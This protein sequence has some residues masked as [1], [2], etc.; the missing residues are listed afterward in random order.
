MINRNKLN[1]PGGLY[2]AAIPYYELVFEIA[3]VYQYDLLGHLDRRIVSFLLFMGMFSFM[4]IKVDD[5]MLRAFMMAV[6]IISL[7]FSIAAILKYIIYGGINLGFGAK[8]IVGGQR[9]GFIYI[10]AFWVLLLSAL[11]SGAYRVIK[12][13]G[14]LIIVIGLFISVARAAIVSLRGSLSG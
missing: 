8:D 1:K 9:Y 14:V 12:L 2:L 5:R 3:V 4:I 7:T 6:V 11:Q 13:V 10:L